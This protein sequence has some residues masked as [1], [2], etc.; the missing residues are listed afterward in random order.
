MPDQ[1]IDN[2]PAS[3]LGN[4]IKMSTAINA[5]EITLSKNGDSSWKVVARF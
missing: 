2:V 1:Q 3:H 4:I 5:V